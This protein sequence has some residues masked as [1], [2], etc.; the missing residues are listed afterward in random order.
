MLRGDELKVSTMNNSAESKKFEEKL[1][2]TERSSD[3]CFHRPFENKIENRNSKQTASRTG[4]RDVTTSNIIT[5]PMGTSSEERY[6]STSSR[7]SS[8]NEKYIFPLF[9]NTNNYPTW[10]DLKTISPIIAKHLKS[11]RHRSS[12]IC[13]DERVST[14]NCKLKTN[15][16]QKLTRD[17][18]VIKSSDFEPST[19][20]LTL[21]K[22]PTI[23][24][25]L[26]L[27][28]KMKTVRNWANLPTVCV[29]Q[30]DIW[31]NCMRR[32]RANKIYD[33]EQSDDDDIAE[34]FYAPA[35]HD[36]QS[37]LLISSGPVPKLKDTVEKLDFL[38]LFG[39]TTHS[40][41]KGTI[42]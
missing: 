41:W 2:R 16:L 21:S 18:F 26:K 9:K 25:L 4:L 28:S 17:E 20:D 24:Q 6:A 23:N 30:L 22:L 8:S 7:N 38:R 42:S 1:N 14:T 5:N 11:D 40:K 34:S 35:R 10:K 3:S 27:N 39:L 13:P 12:V 33:Y 36:V 37:L 19:S 15:S 29:S 32:C 31:E